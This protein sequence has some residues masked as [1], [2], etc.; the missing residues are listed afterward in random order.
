MRIYRDNGFA[1]IENIAAYNLN[2]LYVELIGN[3]IR[4]TQLGSNRGEIRVHY[5]IIRDGFGNNIGETLQDVFDYVESV[6]YGNSTGSSSTSKPIT[7]TIGTSGTELSNSRRY[8]D[9]WDIERGRVQFNSS[10]AIRV[11]V[12]YSLD[13]GNTLFVLVPE[14]SYVGSNPYASAWFA[15]P[16]EIKANNVL[17]RAVGIGLFLTVN[18]VEF[19]FG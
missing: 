10:S 7:L 1:V 19:S 3:N 16:A 12:Y 9:L 13:Y 2:Q 11:H 14:D 5:T 8:V 6:I 18:Y 4:I 17:L 15:L